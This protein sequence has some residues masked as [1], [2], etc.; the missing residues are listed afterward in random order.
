MAEDHPLPHNLAAERSV[1]GAILIRNDAYVVAAA[2]LTEDGDWFR[3]HHRDI[4]RAMRRLHGRGQTIDLVPVC[5]ELSD[6]GKLKAVGGQAYVSSLTDGVPRSTNVEHYA[7]IVGMN[8][9]R[10]ALL[11]QSKRA[12]PETLAAL[13]ERLAALQAGAQTYE[14]LPYS[15]ADWSATPEPRHWLVD[16]LLPAGRLALL[17][18]AG[19]IGKSRLLLQIAARVAYDVDEPMLPTVAGAA[20]DASRAVAQHRD[21]PYEAPYVRRHGRAIIVTWEDETNEFQRRIHQAVAAGAVPP[22]TKWIERFHVVNMRAIG[23]PIWGPRPGSYGAVGAWTE[24]GHRLLALLERD[25]P[26]LLALD[27]TA[28]AYGCNEID[29]AQVRVFCSALDGAAERYGTTIVLCHHPPKTE[30]SYSGSTDW[31]NACRALLTLGRT[32][33]GYFRVADEKKVEA[34]ALARE[35][36]NYGRPTDPVWLVDHWSKPDD[37]H[38]FGQLAWF[39]AGSAERAAQKADDDENVLTD[40][41]G[42]QPKR[43]AKKKKHSDGEGNP[44]QRNG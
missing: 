33:T 36:G 13:T 38:Q 21:A 15:D 19:E 44:F 29:R 32:C 41:A 25:R 10:R 3:D 39:A 18:G 7:S 6:L 42:P 37:K 40:S 26:A 1:L 12:S 31:R 4:W 11:L 17:T 24:A 30:S 2:L 20:A 34:P 28:A 14:P 27:P 23:G 16:D 9:C 35:K 5:A 22:L 43:P 8:A